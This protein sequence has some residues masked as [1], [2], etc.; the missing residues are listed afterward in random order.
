MAALDLKVHLSFGL[1]GKSASATPT[2]P[3]P[4]R[5]IGQ[6]AEPGAFVPFVP[7]APGEAARALCSRQFNA[8]AQRSARRTN[9][10]RLVTAFISLELI[11]CPALWLCCS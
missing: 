4:P 3:G 10:V 1:S 5:N 6:F 8:R 11:Q 9:M 2:K 7:I